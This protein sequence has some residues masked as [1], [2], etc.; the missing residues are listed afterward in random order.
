MRRDYP[1]WTPGGGCEPHVGESCTMTLAYRGEPSSAYR[2]SAC[3]KLHDAPRVHGFCPRCG[4]EVSAVRE[5]IEHW[6]P[7]PAGRRAHG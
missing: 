1:K 2:C 3:G 4:A 6:S 7:D 5:G